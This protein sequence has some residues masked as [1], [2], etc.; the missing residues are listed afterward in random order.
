MSISD[1]VKKP[2]NLM[3]FFPEMQNAKKNP[4]GKGFRRWRRCR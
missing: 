1:R 4:A 3:D 2:G